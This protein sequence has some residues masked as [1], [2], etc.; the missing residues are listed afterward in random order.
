MRLRT[1]ERVKKMKEI[2][3]TISRLVLLMVSVVCLLMV[4]VSA[5][6]YSD[7]SSSGDNSLYSL[8]LENAVSCE[9]EFYYA[10]LEYNVK[11]SADTKELQLDPVKS[12]DSA[13]I[14]DI[15]GTTLSDDGT[16]TVSISVQAA[17]GAVATY[18]LHVTSDGT[19]AE[20]ETDTTVNA[21]ESEA[22]A[23]SEKLAA[24][25]EKAAQ[26]EAAAQLEQKN[27]QVTALQKENDDFASR[28][29]KMMKVLYGLIAF[30]VILLFVIINQSLRNKD[31]KDEIKT[32]KGQV[33]ESY[34]YARKEQNM[35]SDYYY[36]PVQNVPQQPMQNQQ[37]NDMSGTVHAA[38]GNAS[39]KL[40]AQP[41]NMAAAKREEAPVLS[42]KELKKQEK[43]AK[44]A[45]KKAKGRETMQQP[46]MEAVI[47]PQQPMQP[48]Q[49]V[50]SQPVQPQQPAQ[51][52]VS[53]Q[54][55]PTMVQSSIEE[56]DVNVDM[57]EL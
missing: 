38:F 2:K 28:L 30:A 22:Q 46:Q 18:I 43:E 11:V 36:A 20:T 53:Q 40:Q 35:R 45:A 7:D 56:P 31:M 32:L 42:K 49:P 51:Q 54:P 4:S 25:S 44:K 16:G 33:T 8:G 39:Q 13:E 50:Q 57:I 24:E 14:T 15:S 1:K 19:A 5:E 55:Q 34:E 48:Q 17:N 47:P 27:Q 52:S 6:D 26:S 12:A 23:E 9:P 41:M 29:D 21:A 3:K 10:T 37:M